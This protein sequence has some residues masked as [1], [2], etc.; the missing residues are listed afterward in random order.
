VRGLADQAGFRGRIEENSAGSARSAQVSWQ[1]SDITAAEEALGWRPAHTL[2][3]ALAE[4]WEG[5]GTP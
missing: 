3:E 5:D 2:D 1:C 4:L